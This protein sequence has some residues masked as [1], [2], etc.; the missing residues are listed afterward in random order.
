MQGLIQYAK[1]LSCCIQR[2]A[3]ELM[4]VTSVQCPCLGD[5]SGVVV[6]YICVCTCVCVH[7]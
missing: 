4:D 6:W 7:Q 2:E 5:M 3:V 1:S